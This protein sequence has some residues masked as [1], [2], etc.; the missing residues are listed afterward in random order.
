MLIK[1]TQSNGQD[2]WINPTHV[3]WLSPS[4]GLDGVMRTMLVFGCIDVASNLP[5]FSFEVNQPVDEV[6]E[7]LNEA[8][9]R[10]CVS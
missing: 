8:I 6:A 10:V 1:I 9:A 3:S 2:I 5:R 7:M 4:K